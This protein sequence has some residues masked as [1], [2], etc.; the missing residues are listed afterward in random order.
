MAWSLVDAFEGFLTVWRAARAQPLERQIEIWHEF[1]KERFP[2]LLEKQLQDYASQGLDWRKIA[3]ERIFPRLEGWMPRI[4][5]A[6]RR[7]RKLCGPICERASRKLNVELDMVFVIYV[8]LGCGAGWATRYQGKPACL[9]G[10]EGIAELGWHTS[11]KLEGL[12]AHELGHLIHEA[13]RGEPLEPLE[14]DP[15]FQ[16]YLEGFAQR[17]EH[18]IL[19]RESWHQAQGEGWLKWCKEH[20]GYLAQEYLR[21][22]IQGEAVSEFFGSWFE[23]QGQKHIGYFLGHEL[24]TQMRQKHRLRELAELPYSDIVTEAQEYC[25]LLADRSDD[26]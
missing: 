25:K 12:I 20:K 5:E 6:H 21:R 13:W 17:L 8:G 10:L 4:Q 22:A 14:G 18:I 15:W 11:E 9:F 26:H 19:G 2:E 3:S 7:L 16:L 24:I 1:Y 23:F